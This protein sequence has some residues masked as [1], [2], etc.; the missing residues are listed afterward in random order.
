MIER[1][2]DGRFDQDACRAKY[3]A[4][5]REARKLSPR[6]AADAE[7]ATAK[8]ELIR[9]RIMQKRGELMPFADHADR[10]EGMLGLVLSSLSIHARAVR[11]AWRSA[12]KTPLEQ[13]VFKTRTAIAEAAKGS[14]MKTMNPRRPTVT[15]RTV[16]CWRCQRVDAS[17]SSLTL[18]SAAERR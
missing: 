12:N 3:L 13:W 8:A 1:R 11:S 10:V 9:I 6:G 14:V 5:L 4:H 2:D 18:L 16:K 17:L 7:F 15:K